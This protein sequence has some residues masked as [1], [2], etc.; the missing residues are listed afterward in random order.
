[1]RRTGCRWARGGIGGQ[2]DSS[3]IRCTGCWAIARAERNH[4]RRCP[5]QENLSNTWMCLSVAL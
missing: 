1:V 3:W 4:P 2:R 5:K